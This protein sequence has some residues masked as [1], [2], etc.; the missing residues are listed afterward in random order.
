MS[1]LCWNCRGLANSRAVRALRK[2]CNP[3]VPDILFLSETKINKIIAENKKHQLG[4]QYSFSVSSVGLSG[5]LCIYWNDSI[6]FSLVSYSQNHICG[7]VKT[8]SGTCWRFVGLYGWPETGNKCKTWTLIRTLCDNF[9]G[10]IL[11]GGDFNEILSYDEKEGGEDNERSVMTPFRDTL[12]DCDL[13]DLGYEGQW[14]T[15]ERGLSMR[16]LV[17]ER[18][19][20][21]VA[22]TKWFDLVTSSLVENLI[23]EKSDHSPIFLKLGMHRRKKKKKKKKRFRF[24]TYWLLDNECEQVVRGAWSGNVGRVEERVQD[25]ARDLRIW[26][27]AK[28]NDLGKQIDELE[29]ELK[30]AK[31]EPLSDESLTRCAN[32]EKRLDEAFD[33]QEAYW[34]LRSRAAEIKDGDRNTSYFHHKASHRKNKNEIKGLYDTD[35]VWKEEQEDIE[36][37]I[38]SYY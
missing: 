24:E 14:F 29:K 23:R 4:F 31:G 21:F 9:E 7:D 13:R 18:L 19:D 8:D 10:P 1:T 38:Q 26:S 17:R 30:E 3:L 20:R 27:S 35:G 5:G 34:Y 16:T 11:F 6:D 33:K 15:W 36:R 22:N 28:F 2:W 12:Q 32:V 25:V 37:I